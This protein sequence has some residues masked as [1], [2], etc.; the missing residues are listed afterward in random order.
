MSKEYYYFVCGLPAINPEDTKLMLTPLM[1][2]HAAQDYLN[3]EDYA[4]L[5][6]MLIPND[7]SNLVNVLHG[8]NNWS[9]E[10]VITM[11]VWQELYKTLKHDPESIL[12]SNIKLTENIPQFIVDYLR[13]ETDNTDLTPHHKM[14]NDLYTLFY[15]SV[16]KHCDG[17]L[18]EWF[19]FD[20][21][22]RNILIALNCRKH[23][24]PVTG[25]LIGNNVLT[26]KLSK[27]TASDFGLGAEYPMFDVLNRL[28]DNPDMIEKEKGI[29]AIRWK[30][31]E[32]KIFFDYFTVPRILAYFIKLRIIY[33]WIHLS[34]AVGEKRFH[35]ILHDLE[36]SLVFPEEFALKR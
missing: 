5:R 34:Q 14:L 35:Q 13:T 18:K 23:N 24:I 28:N 6:M 25:H 8:K 3:K 15:D 10:S 36:S 1:F 26:E 11:E 4:L 30:W 2:F 7:I 33:R 21:E 12:F 27:S 16:E 31:I 17:F 9:D 22:I 32:N 20:S 19:R 29:D